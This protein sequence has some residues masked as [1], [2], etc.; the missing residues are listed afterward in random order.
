MVNGELSKDRDPFII[1]HS[2]FTIDLIISDL[3][4]P[5]MD[6]FQFLEKVKSDDR[7][8]HL[9]FIMLT[10]KVDDKA[11]LRAL[12][13]G[14]DDYL[15]K[16]FV[17]VELKARIENLLHNY[18][19]RMEMFSQNEDTAEGGA[20]ENRPVITRTDA[21]WLEEVEGKLTKYLPEAD[22]KMERVAAEMFLS[23]RQFSRKLKGL[24]GLTPSQYLKEIRLNRSKELL[25]SKKYKTIKEVASAVGFTDARH[26]S[27]LFQA[28]FGALPSGFLR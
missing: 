3:M 2:S 12:R 16:P 27:D 11:K 10:A 23:H 15:T 13:V 14:V 8:R 25:L 24:T 1:H 22:L 17:E 7:W 6:G 4:M 5:V 19:Q 18:W 26:F 20:V 28:H 9:P 21:E